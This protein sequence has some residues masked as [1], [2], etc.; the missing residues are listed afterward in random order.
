MLQIF[1]CPIYYNPGNPPIGNG[2]NHVLNMFT[3]GSENGDY[4]LTNSRKEAAPVAL[5][6]NPAP[7]LGIETKPVS[8]SV[9]LL[10]S[11]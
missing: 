3:S 5:K 10:I 6:G 7:R 4:T 9:L 1:G 2:I 8:L 11:Y